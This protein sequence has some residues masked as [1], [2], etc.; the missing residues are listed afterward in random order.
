MAASA[1]AMPTMACSPAQWATA[2][3]AMA[4]RPATRSLRWLAVG[5]ATC[6]AAG[7]CEAVAKTCPSMPTSPRACSNSA[8]RP[9]A[10][11]TVSVRCIRLKD[12][13]V[14]QGWSSRRLRIKASSV[15]QSMLSMRTVLRSAGPWP[16]S[17]TV[18]NWTSS[19]E[20][21]AASSRVCVPTASCSTLTAL[22][23]KSG[24]TSRTPATRLKAL[25]TMPNS[26]GQ[27]SPGTLSSTL[28]LGF[29]VGAASAASPPWHPHE[30]HPSDIRHSC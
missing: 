30:L 1:S 22:R 6:A 12:S 9:G 4:S 27:H 24:V 5:L 13:P 20:A 2:S 7:A 8:C 21:R 28:L 29:S 18:G 16:T 15:G 19:P 3:A 25:S 17:T 14:T 23:T 11:S 26:V 10:W